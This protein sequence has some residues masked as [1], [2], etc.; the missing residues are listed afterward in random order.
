MP[1]CF[2]KGNA[3]N[4]STTEP[5]AASRTYG[6]VRLEKY[7]ARSA[8]LTTTFTTLGLSYSVRSQI[9]VAAVDMGAWVKA[10]ATAS[11]TAGSI[12]GSSPWMLI[13]ASQAM[14]WTTSA[15]RS[16]PLG[17]SGEVISTWQKFWATSQIRVSSVATKT[18]LSDLAFWH[19]ST[20]CWMRGL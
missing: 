6:I 1:K 8:E 17:C 19:R 14:R 5:V 13:A 11:M 12:I 7:N 15:I 9:A 4:C 3:A 2:K 16:V 18:S 10:L 20:T